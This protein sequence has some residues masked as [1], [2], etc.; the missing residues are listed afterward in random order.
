[1]YFCIKQKLKINIIK[2]Y[3]LFT[4][5]SF[6]FLTIGF[7]KSLRYIYLDECIFIFYNFY[8]NKIKG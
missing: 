5:K 6:N 4:E 8:L 1:M 3:Y 7:K 2:F